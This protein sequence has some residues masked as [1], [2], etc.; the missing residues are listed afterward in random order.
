MAQQF[1]RAGQL[2]SQGQKLAPG[3]PDFA[4]G[5]ARL[6]L[7]RG[8]LAAAR[9]GAAE[10]LEKHPRHGDALLVLGL[11]HLREGNHE[12]ARQALERGAALSEQNGEFLDALS[13]LGE[14]ERRRP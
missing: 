11:V 5:L 9:K 4:V 3:N 12:P 14:A 8:N 13:H 2:Y 10:V 6:A 7:H 1:E